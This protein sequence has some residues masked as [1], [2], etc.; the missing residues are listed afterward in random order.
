MTA[1]TGAESLIAKPNAAS[2]PA[3][4]DATQSG[5]DVEDVRNGVDTAVRDITTSL[6]V[7]KRLSVKEILLEKH[8]PIV[9]TTRWEMLYEIFTNHSPQI[10]MKLNISAEGM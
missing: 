5:N 4:L 8:A 1:E 7:C 2:P 10:L 3:K 9:D 6:V